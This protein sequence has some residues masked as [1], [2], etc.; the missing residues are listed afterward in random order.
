M[1][2]KKRDRESLS[3][4]L[5]LSVSV[6]LSLSLSLSLTHTHQP[7]H[8]YLH[9]YSQIH[10][11]IQT[12]LTYYTGQKKRF[13]ANRI[14]TCREELGECKACRLDVYNNKIQEAL[15]KNLKLQT[16]LVQHLFLAMCH[17]LC[18]KNVCL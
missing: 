5:S 4:S 3:L 14:E 11:H 7:T 17:L 1:R 9:T 8:L 12:L 10:I 18:L 16:N 15:N 6:C 13:H 2:D